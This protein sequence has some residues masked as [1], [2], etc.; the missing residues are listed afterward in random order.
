VTAAELAVVG[1]SF[2]VGN[3]VAEFGQEVLK[4]EQVWAVTA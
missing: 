4:L 1:K 2:V 3:L